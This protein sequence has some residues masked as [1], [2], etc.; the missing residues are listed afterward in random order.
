MAVDVG[1]GLYTRLSQL[2]EGE[3]LQHWDGMSIAY[4]FVCIYIYIYTYINTYIYIRYIYIYIYIYIYARP[5]LE[6]LT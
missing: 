6:G 4:I 2:E 3:G 5:C 1:Q